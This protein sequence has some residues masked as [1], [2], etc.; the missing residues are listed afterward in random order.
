M[1]GSLEGSLVVCVYDEI[2]ALLGKIE[3]QGFGL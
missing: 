1:C 2:L 3:L